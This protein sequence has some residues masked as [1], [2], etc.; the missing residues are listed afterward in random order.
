MT[1]ERNIC[2]LYKVLSRSFNVQRQML[3]SL[4]RL[5]SSTK[6]RLDQQSITT[7]ESPAAIQNASLE[8]GTV[9]P[10]V[11]STTNTTRARKKRKYFIRHQLYT[12]TS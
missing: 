7:M 8:S 1:T 3:E 11:E 4:Q 10:A 9:G 12:L 5:E 2:D 6:S